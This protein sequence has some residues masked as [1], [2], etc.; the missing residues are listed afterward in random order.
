MVGIH[1]KTNQTRYSSPEKT[2]YVERRSLYIF[3]KLP[4]PIIHFN[5]NT[6]F[7]QLLIENL[8]KTYSNGVQAL[9]NVSLNIPQGM[10]G[11]LGPN[12]A[13]KSTL[14]RTLATLQ[15]ADSGRVMLGDTDV[16]RDKQAI[17]KVLG[18][19]P[20]EFGVYPR[21]SAEMMLN[22]IAQLKGL[23]H[24]K[25]REETV[26]ALLQKVNLWDAR[27][28]NL[29]TY[30]G[31]MK[32][33]FGIA[34]AL[35]GNPRLL[36]VDEP[37]AGL[38]PAERTRFYNLLSEVGENTII[39]LSTHIVEDVKTL[40]RNMAIICGGEVMYTGTPQDAVAQLSGK[41][42]SKAIDKQD[43]HTYR[44]QYHVIATQ[45]SSGRLFIR[46][47]DEQRPEDGFEAAEPGLEDV[48]FH[49]ISS[50]VDLVTL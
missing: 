11:L 6:L 37:T 16:L 48:Y 2:P 35:I 8:S 26:A 12:G 5:E 50:K 9:Q 36:I 39:I 33:R 23:D 19:L 24:K 29:G 31:G 7:M 46:V 42:W 44:A 21:I 45:M 40:C 4:L 47:V 17:R 18:Y 20:Q 30:S 34:Q 28:R 43:V 38:D 22:H 15:D 1:Q 14:M 27:K 49:A 32:Q 10:F 25:E 41:V 3:Q 13:G